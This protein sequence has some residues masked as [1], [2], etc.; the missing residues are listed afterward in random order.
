MAGPPGATRPRGG[1]ALDGEVPE[2][3]EEVVDLG[4]A[5]VGEARCCAFNAPGTLL[6]VGGASGVVAVVDWALR[7][8][9]TVL[10][11][12]EADGGPATSAVAAVGFGPGGRL[13]CVARLDALETWD[14][15]ERRRLFRAP[16]ALPPSRCELDPVTGATC[17][18]AGAKGRP[19]LVPVAA[20]APPA[21]PLALSEPDGPGAEGT[22]AAYASGGR[23]VIAGTTRGV[24]DVV[25]ARTNALVATVKLGRGFAVKALGVEPCGAGNVAVCCADGSVRVLELDAATGAFLDRGQQPFATPVDAAKFG[26]ALALSPGGTHAVTASAI[27]TDHVLHVWSAAQERRVRVL[28]GPAGTGGIAALAWHPTAPVV[29]AIGGTASAVYAWAPRYVE[30]WSAFAPDFLELDQ[31]AEYTEREDEFDEGF[32]GA[33][34]PSAASPGASDDAGDDEDEIVSIDE[35]DPMAVLDDGAPAGYLRFVPGVH[36]LPPPR[37]PT[38]PADARLPPPPPQ[39]ALGAPKSSAPAKASS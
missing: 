10:A 28:E 17:L 20:G 38:G 16:L 21:M 27:K 39:A 13:C 34:A 2:V 3:L 29:C 15:A 30:R 37:P 24:V 6:L 26:T 11:A 14:V 12:A 8:P 19:M 33:G 25:C 22:T 32:D 18:V 35:D 31:N 7:K 1:V 4:A 9:V 5:G 23:V 36:H